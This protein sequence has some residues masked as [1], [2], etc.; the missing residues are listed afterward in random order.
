MV[1]SSTLVMPC[2]FCLCAS[3]RLLCLTCTC[4]PGVTIRVFRAD[5]TPLDQLNSSN[6]LRPP[7]LEKNFLISPPGSPPVGW[8]QIREDPPNS[9]PLA[10][11][12]IA[13]LKQLEIERES[14]AGV[15]VLI[16]PD[17]DEGITIFV[18]DC[19][20]D[21]NDEASDQSS[22]DDDSEWVYGQTR[23]Q[24]IKPAPVARLPPTALP[25][26]TASA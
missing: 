19:D 3:D 7:Q 9:T 16:E 20:A 6:L 12:L 22:E 5:P 21:A 2:E 26:L 23:R 10:D 25:P 24:F 11:D 15:E 13:A 14:K 17:N 1:S 18:E 8:E 4:S